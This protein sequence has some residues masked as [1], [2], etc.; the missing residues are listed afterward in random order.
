MIHRRILVLGLALVL[1]A[2]RDSGDA[3]EVVIGIL[4]RAVDQQVFLFIDQ[5][6]AIVLAHFEIGRQLD[7]VSGACLLAVAAID[8]AGEVDAEELG[9]A[10]AVFIFGGLQ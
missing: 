5:V 4:A 2:D 10:A 3:P 7:G 1:A 6:L 8:A 9:V